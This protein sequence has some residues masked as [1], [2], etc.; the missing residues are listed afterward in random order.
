M[1][2]MKR[3]TVVIDVMDKSDNVLDRE[4]RTHHPVAHVSTSGILHF[5]ILQMKSC[6]GEVLGSARMVV[7]KMRDNHILD[8][9]TVD[10]D[11]FERGLWRAQET[12][13][14]LR[15]FRLAE[16]RIHNNRAVLADNRPDKEIQRHGTVVDVMS[17]E[18]LTCLTLIMHGISQRIDFVR[19]NAVT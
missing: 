3:D 16:T 4:R 14:A 17:D 11:A 1:S 13:T 7:V 15:G 6:V 5:Q 10:V 2:G 9:A 19:R 12:S 18:I 8:P